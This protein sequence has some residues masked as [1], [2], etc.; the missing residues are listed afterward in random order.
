[1]SNI[2]YVKTDSND[3]VEWDEVTEEQFES[4]RGIALDTGDIEMQ[5]PKPKTMEDFKDL[6]I[7]L[8]RIEDTYRTQHLNAIMEAQGA[9][10]IDSLEM[11]IDILEADEYIFYPD[12]GDD[13]SLGELMFGDFL[14]SLS[15]T[16]KGEFPG[17]LEY[18]IDWE[19]LGRD[20]RINAGGT[21]T[22]YG[23]I[24]IL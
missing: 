24:E 2:L 11:C 7:A 13:R 3:Y 22:D 18:Y 15:D 9:S 19:S 12:V 1:M 14:D 10:N 20:Y 16:T 21:Y 8:E 5:Y 4:A 6:G 17:S 23:Y